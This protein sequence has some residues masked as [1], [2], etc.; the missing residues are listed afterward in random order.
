PVTSMDAPDSTVRAPV[1]FSVR[2]CALVPTVAGCV[3]TAPVFTVSVGEVIEVDARVP[4]IVVDVVAVI[5]DAVRFPLTVTVAAVIDGTETLPLVVT[6][7]PLT[8]SVSVRTTP[9]VVGPARLTTPFA[10]S[11]IGSGLETRSPAGART[12]SKR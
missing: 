9:G 11:R 7:V 5:A 2:L 3:S 10:P 1:T 12:V 4:K 8:G 6:S